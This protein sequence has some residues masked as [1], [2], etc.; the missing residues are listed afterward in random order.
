MYHDVA[1]VPATKMD[2]MKVAAHGP[3]NPRFRLTGFL[4]TSE[5]E[6]GVLGNAGIAT[7]RAL[8][9]KTLGLSERVTPGSGRCW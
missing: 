7:Q 6:M 5:S 2:T 9:T 4:A 3:I 1:E 8:G